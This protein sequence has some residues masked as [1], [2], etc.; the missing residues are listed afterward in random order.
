MVI[1]SSRQAKNGTYNVR[2]KLPN[3]SLAPTID[4]PSSVTAHC[5][6]VRQILQLRGGRSF[7]ANFP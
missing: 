2:G 1:E 3:L 4:G 7:E 5:C 6:E